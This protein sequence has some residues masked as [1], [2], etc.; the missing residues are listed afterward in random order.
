MVE[1]Y[2]CDDRV[3]T[4]TPADEVLDRLVRTFGAARD[5]QRA[6]PMTAYMRGQFP[7][8]GLPSPTW[9]RLA[10]TVVAGLPDPTADELRTVALA[11]WDL[12]ERE[13]QYFA[14]DHLRRHV[15]VCGPDLLATAR[16]L[17]TTRSWWD[18]VD[19][20]ATGF[21]GALVA[22][23]PRLR[24]DMDAWSVDDNLWL[25]RSAILH[26][27]HHGTRT[28]ADRL[29]GYC[30]RQAGHPDFFVRKGIGWA[31]R[32]YARTDPGAVR[33]FIARHRDRLSPLSVREATK[34]L[35]DHP[36]REDGDDR[37]GHRGG[38]EPPTRPG[39]QAADE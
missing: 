31:L 15:A 39:Q 22:A 13:Y 16:T 10:R 2:R 20:L 34:H 29:L 17:V 23:H 26:Q 24:A 18:T 12:P 33:Q 38:D 37:A 19:P 3:M 11:C 4:R 35:A 5:P 8:L 7:Y 30:S 9:R 25:V 1:P 27:L 21:V 36:H 14:C 32:Q 28:D 6:A